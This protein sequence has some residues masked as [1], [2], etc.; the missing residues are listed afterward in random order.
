MK[1]RKKGFTILEIIVCL[2]VLM[3]IVGI[4]SINFITNLNSTNDTRYKEAIEK[5]ESAS[6][7]YVMTVKNDL[8]RTYEDIKLVMENV[9]SFSYITL[10][11][12]E[13]NGFLGENQLKNPIT[14]EKFAGLVKFTNTKGKYDFEYIDDPKDIV[15]ILFERN[16]ADSISRT[17]Q[18]IIC[19][20]RDVAKCAKDL[21]LPSITRVEGRSFGWSLEYD[22]KTSNHKE[23]TKIS[24]LLS[25][26]KYDIIENKVRLYAITSKENSIYFDTGDESLGTPRKLS[27]T[28]YNTTPACE[29]TMPDYDVDVY[30][31]K[32]GWNTNESNTG[33]N[34]L[35]GTSLTIDKTITLY[36]SREVKGFDVL[37]NKLNRISSTTVVPSNINIIL[38]LD[39]SSSMSA[40]NRIGNLKK[41]TIGL[42]DR[43]NFDNS[44]VS[45]I[46]FSSGSTIR[47]GFN[48]DRL[49]IKSEINR[50]NASG[51][52]SFTS[53]IKTAATLVDLK[54]NDKPCF[55]ILVSDGYSYISPD[56]LSLLNLKSQAEIYTMGIGVGADQQYLRL[57][58]SKPQNYYHYDEYSDSSTLTNF[59]Q[60][61]DDIVQNIMIIK[62]DG[63]ENAIPTHV[64]NGNLE[65]GNLVISDKY[66][67]DIYLKDT[68]LSSFT[69]ENDYFYKENGLYYFD[70]Y[71]YALAN[72]KVGLPNMKNLRIKFFYTE[73]K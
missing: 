16:G 54:P 15:T 44:T 51:G 49:R 31:E 30:H 61:F 68:R 9:G 8:N 1:N 17:A 39:V 63:I 71:N 28:V 58:A 72:P 46:P 50:L 42:I 24:D 57:I 20:D 37:V 18:A 27:C 67:L 69:N 47:L 41:V 5:L 3:I 7:A 2:G 64:E 73:D 11:E 36:L 6:D 43:I 14:K 10:E 52:T 26:K 34:F 23:G 53:A 48:Q 29:V 59:Y 66:P 38:A 40:N 55:V 45:L 62:G 32:K 33:E 12:L 60:L 19:P 21:L 22:A 56:D 13:D 25:S 4:F 35:P 70:I 65:L